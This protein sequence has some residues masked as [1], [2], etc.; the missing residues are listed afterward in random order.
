MPVD[1]LRGI[2]DTGPAEAAA[3]AKALTPGVPPPPA[4]FPA[5]GTDAGV[6]LPVRTAA[7]MPPDAATAAGRGV[8]KSAAAWEAPTAGGA[9]RGALAGVAAAAAGVAGVAAPDGLP[10]CPLSVSPNLLGAVPGV[11]A[12][13]G[14]AAGL[15]ADAGVAAEPAALLPLRLSLGAPGVPELARARGLLNAP[16]KVRP[17]GRGADPGMTPGRPPAAGVGAAAACCGSCMGAL[18]PC[19]WPPASLKPFVSPGLWDGVFLM[20]SLNPL[21][22]PPVR[23]LIGA[24]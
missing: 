8:L 5:V 20:L 6:A 17:E 10:P 14:C 22:P 18:L 23:L 9:E 1:L 3:A 2:A 7:C 16:F 4:L 21:P 24:E 11:A 13:A 12:A 19:L 15:A